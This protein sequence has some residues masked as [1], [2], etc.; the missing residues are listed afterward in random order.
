MGLQSLVYLVDDDSDGRAFMADGLQE[1]GLN[2]I[3]HFIN[4]EQVIKAL[5]DAVAMPDLIFLNVCIPLIDGF[6]VMSFVEGLPKAKS[7][8]L[9]LMCSSK[10]EW[11]SDLTFKHHFIEKSD[12]LSVREQIQETAK[13]LLSL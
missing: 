8:K 7:T 12:V 4:G 5:K 10:P 3:E 13:H 2:N 6:G 1:L 9:C 11:L